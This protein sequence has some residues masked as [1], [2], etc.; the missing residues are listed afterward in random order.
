VFPAQVTDNIE[1]LLAFDWNG[2]VAPFP[3][4]SDDQRIRTPFQPADEEAVVLVDQRKPMVLE[5]AE[6]QQEQPSSQPRAGFEEGALVGAFVGDR[7]RDHRLSGDAVDEIEFE[8]GNV[9]VSRW[10]R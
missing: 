9:R 8:P 1:D 6:V 5:K 2:A 4:F 3:Q 10:E 7:P